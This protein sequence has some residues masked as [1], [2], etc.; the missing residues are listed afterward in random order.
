MSPNVTVERLILMGGGWVRACVRACAC[1]RVRVR[2]RV[3]ACFPPLE[4]RDS[5]VC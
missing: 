4:I 5:S 1:A 3:C 2:A